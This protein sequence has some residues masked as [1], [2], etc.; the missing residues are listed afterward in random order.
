MSGYLQELR[1]LD[2]KGKDVITLYNEISELAMREC[3]TRISAKEE[4]NAY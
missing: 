3:T 4:R 2:V 1:N